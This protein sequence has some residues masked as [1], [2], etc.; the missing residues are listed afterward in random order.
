MTSLK[1]KLEK[2]EF[3]I[4]AEITPKLTT[5]GHT[6]VEQARPLKGLVDAVNV[7]DGAGA[8]VSMSSLAASALLVQDGIDPV[9]QLTCRDRNRIAIAA[10]L[11]GAAALGIENIL[12]LTGDDPTAGD[13]PDA[14]P[15]F[16]LASSD[17]IELARRMTNEGQIAS[18]R[19]LAERPS[20]Y[21]GA[22][23]APF[24]PPPDWRPEKLQA[25][26]DAGIDFVQTQYCFDPSIVEHY[27]EHLADYGVL[28][29]LSIIVGIGPL[30]SVRSARWMNDNLFGVNI[31][32]SLIIRMQSAR[33][34]KK[35]G[36]QICVELI[37]RYRDMPG[38]AGVHLMAPMQSADSVASVIAEAL[39]GIR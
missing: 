37:R 13:E 7:T 23:D 1:A 3:A 29:Q 8:R 14:I 32:E 31:P 34:K 21:V 28:E 35:E 26:I 20:F 27:F 10:D 15:V 16:D 5:D 9:W 33:D 2:S 12:V 17:V 30:A 22:A 6:I 19:D 39:A 24:E 36:Q 38:V 11:I 4:T 18:G 25:K